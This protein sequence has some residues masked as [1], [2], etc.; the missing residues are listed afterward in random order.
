MYCCCWQVQGQEAVGLGWKH[1]PECSYAWES[2]RPDYRE[3][4]YDKVSSAFV[5]M[6]RLLIWYFHL[7][8]DVRDFALGVSHTLALLENGALRIDACRLVCSAFWR[9]DII[10]GTVYSFGSNSCLQL[11]IG[12]LLES[13]YVYE[14]TEVLFPV[15]TRIALIAAGS[16][17]SAA[18]TVDGLVYVWGDATTCFD[19]TPTERFLCKPTLVRELASLVVV[20]VACGREHTLFVV[21]TGAVYAAGSNEYSQV[22]RWSFATTCCVCSTHG[23]NLN[24][25]C[26]R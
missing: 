23:P 15:G 10:I 20:S 17:H 6:M 25:R 24:Q 3:V 19:P 9:S 14:P 1:L 22:S 5:N 2:Q 11:G 26:L 7:Y 8:S 12:S 21:A 13:Q 4:A 18:I 16:S